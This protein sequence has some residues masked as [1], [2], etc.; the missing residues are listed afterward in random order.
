[1]AAPDRVRPVSSWW[2]WPRSVATVAFGAIFAF[3]LAGWAGSTGQRCSPAGVPLHAIAGLGGWLTLTA[4]GVSYRLL[5]MF[6]LA[7][8]VDDRKSRVTLAAGAL[9]VAVAVAGG[10][11]RDLAGCRIERRAGDRCCPRSVGA[12]LYGRDVAGHFQ[13][14]QAASA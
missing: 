1:M 8:D 4:M 5:S 13:Q 3:A 11:A 10:D 9:A 2:G 7:P 6:M 14:P 12:A